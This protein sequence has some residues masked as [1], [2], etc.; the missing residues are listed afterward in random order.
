M[1]FDE[2]L[3]FSVKKIEL[4]KNIYLEVRLK[5]LILNKKIENQKLLQSN[6]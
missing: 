6:F 1:S 3:A 5:A 2:I 4:K